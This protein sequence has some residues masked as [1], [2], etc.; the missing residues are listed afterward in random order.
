MFAHKNLLRRSDQLSED[1]RRAV[2]IYK[3]SHYYITDLR[4]RLVQLTAFSSRS[5][6]KRP[7]YC[8]SGTII[9]STNG[10]ANDMLDDLTAHNTAR[11]S[12]CADVNKCIFHVGTRLT[13]SSGG[14]YLTGIK[15]S[16]S[17]AERKKFDEI[18]T[19]CALAC[20]QPIEELNTDH[21]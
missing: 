6:Y 8:R 5:L 2:G 19:V 15:N 12:T 1:F 7:R 17:L 4:S 16:R 10:N 9:T 11:E 18:V 14:W 13:Y 20:H 21:R 3:F